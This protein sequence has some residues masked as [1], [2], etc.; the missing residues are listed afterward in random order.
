QTSFEEAAFILESE[1][2][3]I[4]QSEETLTNQKN[5]LETVQHEYTQ[6][7]D[8]LKTIEQKLELNR[9]SL[10]FQEEKAANV[11]EERARLIATTKESTFTPEAD[12][13][14]MLLE[15]T[16]ILKTSEIELLQ[17]EIQ[18]KET[19]HITLKRELQA[20]ELEQRKLSASRNQLAGEV[21][22]LEKMA[23]SEEK[24]GKAP[25][26][27][28]LKVKEGWNSAVDTILRQQLLMDT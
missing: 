5:V 14:T 1:A 28:H 24:A 8:A 4:W 7:R 26:F 25:L 6:I 13:E 21:S 9:H 27:E 2:D 23:V 10:K 16:M 3:L 17:Q 11:I 19:S 15:E 18:T 20:L 12:S 22:M